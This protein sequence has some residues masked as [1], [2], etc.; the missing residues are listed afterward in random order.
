MICINIFI[1]LITVY[2]NCTPYVYKNHIPQKQDTWSLDSIFLFF[3]IIPPLSTRV[4]S[5]EFLYPHQFIFHFLWRL[6]LYSPCGECDSVLRFISGNSR[7]KDPL[8]RVFFFLVSSKLLLPIHHAVIWSRYY[9]SF[10]EKSKISPTNSTFFVF[11][12]NADVTDEY[13]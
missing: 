12:Y 13:S 1:F 10:F 3:Y 7:E 11:L 6:L 2:K 8:E 4:G 9:I 5:G